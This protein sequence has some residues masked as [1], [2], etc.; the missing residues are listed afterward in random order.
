[1]RDEVEEEVKAALAAFRSRA[2]G[3]EP[4]AATCSVMVAQSSQRWHVE[5]LR[6]YGTLFCSPSPKD[7]HLI[8]AIGSK[9]AGALSGFLVGQPACKLSHGQERS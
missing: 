3:A 6:S 4:L 9:R 2:A 7:S 8:I 1:M 5:R